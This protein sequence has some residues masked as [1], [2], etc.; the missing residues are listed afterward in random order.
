M[1]KTIWAVGG[2]KGGTGKSFVAS[3]LGLS[4]AGLGH[5]V[6]LVDADLYR[7]LKTFK[8]LLILNMAR[9]ERDDLLGKSI[10]QVTR[11]HLL[12]DLRFLGTV[13]YDVRLHGC[14]IDRTPF[15]TA[16]PASDVAASFR[17][18]A[19]DL[20]ASGVPAS[21]PDESRKPDAL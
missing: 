14:L 9:N 11:R 5:D 20:A 17:R 16:H 3:S 19:E 12:L 13:P 21:R 8:P 10:A 15:L 2:G 18:I 6:V 4:L 1:D 7:A